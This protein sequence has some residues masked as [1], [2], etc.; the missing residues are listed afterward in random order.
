MADLSSRQDDFRRH[1]MTIVEYLVFTLFLLHHN[2]VSL[3]ADIGFDG[4][5]MLDDRDQLEAWI[6]RRSALQ[7]RRRGPNQ[8]AW[9][10]LVQKQLQSSKHSPLHLAPGE[11]A[12]I[13]QL[14]F[15][16][17]CS[18]FAK[19]LVALVRQALCCT[20]S[21]ASPRRSGDRKPILRTWM[22]CTGM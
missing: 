11:V 3:E 5:L 8:A 19:T 15:G 17:S 20:L 12:N 7:D 22:A 9:R 21:T 2:A 18:S 16:V 10:M 4:R 13:S 1:R 14:T 6:E